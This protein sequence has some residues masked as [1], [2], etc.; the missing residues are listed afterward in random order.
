MTRLRMNIEAI[1]DSVRYVVN[2]DGQR[3]A[4]LLDMPTWDALRQL[5][6]EITED[7]L[8]GR[9]M[10]EVEDDEMFKGEAS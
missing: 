4:V 10:D 2:K 7:E 1:L 8:L 5:L 9:L 3:T 6:E